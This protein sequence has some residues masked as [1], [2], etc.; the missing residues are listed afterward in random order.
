MTLKDVKELIEL[1]HAKGFA[2]FEIAQADF[3]LKIVAN[4]P[5]VYAAPPAIAGAPVM[6]VPAHAESAAPVAAPTAAAPAAAAEETL[7]IVKSPIVGTFYRSPGPTA[8]PFAKVGDRVDVGSVLCIVEAMKLMNE[9]E[10][11]T[12]GE[13]IKVFVENAQ[14]VEYGQPLFGIRP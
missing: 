7:V 10:S 4:A 2:E 9:I 5:V 8:D 14:P 11:D 12:A 13:I 6:I 1:V 3:T